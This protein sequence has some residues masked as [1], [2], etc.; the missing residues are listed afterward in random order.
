MDHI[1]SKFKLKQKAITRCL[2]TCL[3]ITPWNTSLQ[4]VTTAVKT[5]SFWLPNVILLLVGKM[6]CAITVTNLS[7]LDYPM[8]A[9]AVRRKL[10]NKNQRFKTSRWCAQA[11]NHTRDKSCLMNSNLAGNLTEDLSFLNRSSQAENS[12]K[13]LVSVTNWVR[14]QHS[15]NILNIIVI[16]LK[17]IFPRASLIRERP[18]MSPG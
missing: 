13:N 15:A 16:N 7:R 18:R 5:C 6:I 4:I 12:T 14:L 10:R 3:N 11:E 17:T 1:A 9:C 8:Y 2:P